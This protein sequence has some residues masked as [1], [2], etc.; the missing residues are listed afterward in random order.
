MRDDGGTADGGV[1]ATVVYVTITVRAVND[2]P[3]LTLGANQVAVL[4]TGLK[5]VNGFAQMTTGP[6][7]EAS[8]G[9]TFTVS[10]NRPDLFTTQPSIDANGTLRYAP[11]ISLGVATVTVTATDDGGIANG[12]ANASSSRTFTVTVIL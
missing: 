7:D 10:T 9:V 12:G 3:T 8:Q 1:D 11:S 4:A 5:T 6:A 2:A